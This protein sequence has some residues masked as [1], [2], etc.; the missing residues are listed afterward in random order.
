[1]WRV[2]GCVDPAPPWVVACFSHRQLEIECLP[3]QFVSSYSDH[4]LSQVKG[5]DCAEGEISSIP[6]LTNQI[7]SRGHCRTVNSGKP[8]CGP[9]LLQRRV[10]RRALTCYRRLRIDQASLPRPGST[11]PR[12]ARLAGGGRHRVGTEGSVRSGAPCAGPGL[13]A[14]RL[15]SQ[16]AWLGRDSAS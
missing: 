1:V 13:P 8:S 10:R 6:G 3:A 12:P 14:R 15:L 2:K 4:G 9:G 11:R 7:S 16:P 5:L